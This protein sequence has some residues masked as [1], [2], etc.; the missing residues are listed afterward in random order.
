MGPVF[1]NLEIRRKKLALIVHLKI[2]AAIAEA[3]LVCKHIDPISTAE[4]LRFL[5]SFTVMMMITM[6]TI[7]ITMTMT[8]ITI[9]TMLAWL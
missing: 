6:I 2:A 1:Q 3:Q 4:E 5:L 8:T 7:T 9:T